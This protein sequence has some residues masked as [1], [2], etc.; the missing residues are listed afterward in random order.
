VRIG[1]PWLVW[2]PR[3]NWEE[4]RPLF[5]PITVLLSFSHGNP[6]HEEQYLT[7]TTE[8]NRNLFVNMKNQNLKKDRKA[9]HGGVVRS[10]V[11]SVFST[12]RH[13]GLGVA[14]THKVLS[15]FQH[16]GART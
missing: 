9:V 8:R 10:R 12:S 6:R 5:S 1:N 11:V 14:L 4:R 3:G 7:T 2:S 15:M 16:P 13:P